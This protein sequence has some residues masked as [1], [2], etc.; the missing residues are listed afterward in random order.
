MK[1]ESLHKIQNKNRNPCGISIENIPDSTPLK[2]LRDQHTVTPTR[3]QQSPSS[4]PLQHL[5]NPY[6]ISTMK[7]VCAKIS[8]VNSVIEYSVCQNQNML[9]CTFLPI[10]SWGGTLGQFFLYYFM[11]TQECFFVI[12]AYIGILFLFDYYFYLLQILF[13]IFNLYITQ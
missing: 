5:Q 1:S 6:A 13:K 4:S 10:K 3:S 11:R 12:Y 8:T 7:S 9:L 2:N